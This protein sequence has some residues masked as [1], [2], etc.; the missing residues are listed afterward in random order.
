V[1]REPAA[2][3]GD[4][5]PDGGPGWWIGETI[6][7]ENP[8]RTLDR[9]AFAVVEIWRVWRE[10]ETWPDAGGFNDQSSWLMEAF[11]ILGTTEKKRA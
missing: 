2:F 8:A 9:C 5:P 7:T 4:A 6:V 3:A 11:L 1:L 10:T